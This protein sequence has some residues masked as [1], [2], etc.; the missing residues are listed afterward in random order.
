MPGAAAK[1]TTISR[2]YDDPLSDLALDRLGR[3]RL[4]RYVYGLLTDTPADWS[5][6][7]G[8]LGEWG[9]GKTTVGK[10]VDQF[11]QR[12]MHLVIWFD[13][14]SATSIGNL[15]ARLLANILDRLSEAHIAVEGSWISRLK[16]HAQRVLERGRE[17]ANAAQGDPYGVSA[18][19]GATSTLLE[20]LVRIDAADIEIIQRTL[21]KRRLIVIID[22]LDRTS[23]LLKNP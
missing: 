19:I 4:A 10:W 11:A 14:W 16:L 22:D 1:I 13:P 15:W 21:D 2:G 20:D 3:G 8:L 5:V 17:V 23:R 9:L 6:R 18:G 12:D 7:V